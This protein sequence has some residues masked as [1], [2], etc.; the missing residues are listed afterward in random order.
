MMADIVDQIVKFENGEM[1]EDE[2]IEFFQVL[3]DTGIVWQLQGMYQRCLRDFVDAGLVKLKKG[4]NDG[5]ESK[6]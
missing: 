2:T 5:K 4:E 1:S 6:N 3:A